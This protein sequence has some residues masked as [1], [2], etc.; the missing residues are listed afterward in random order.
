MLLKPKRK[1]EDILLD[2]FIYLSLFFL[3]VVTLYPFLHTLAVSFND[4]LDSI[5]GGIYLW[6]RKFTTFNYKTMLTRTQTFHAAWISVARTVLVTV[7]GTFFTAML[8]Y[9]VSRKDFVLRKFISFIY[10]LTMYVSGGLIPTYFLYQKLGL[11]NNFWVYVLPG[12]VHAFN[13]IIIR[14]YIHDLPESLVESAKIDG[15]SE[16]TIFLRIILPLCKPVLATIAI[17]TAVYHWNAWWDVFLYNS[18]NPALS[19]LA[20]ELQKVLATAQSMSGS[21]EQAMSQAAAGS[22]QITPRSIRATMTIIVTVPI[23]VIYPFMQK[24]FV[25]GL[26]LGGVKE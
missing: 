23:A 12:L 24:Y 15:A 26:T 3:I 18:S 2:S 6:P 4:G 7:F 5:K 19:T 25:H 10:V 16:L 22:N 8:A 14:T 1:L 20:Y 9:V 11:T 17:F 21:M 13:L